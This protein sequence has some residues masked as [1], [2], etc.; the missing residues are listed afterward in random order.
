MIF[1]MSLGYLKKVDSSLQFLRQDFTPA[2]YLGPHFSSNRSSSSNAVC[3]SGELKY[4][5][6]KAS[7]YNLAVGFLLAQDRIFEVRAWNENYN[8]RNKVVGFEE[9]SFING[10]PEYAA[11][12]YR[13]DQNDI[14][15]YDRN[16]NVEITG[17]YTW[18][19]K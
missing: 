5:D 13:R 17:I 10:K 3:H 19:G 1:R 8:F 16:D 7:Q 14:I 9:Y 12:D 18:W 4:S 6:P 15:H 11:Y 2:G